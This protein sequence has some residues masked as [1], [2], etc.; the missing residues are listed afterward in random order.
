MRQPQHEARMSIHGKS[1]AQPQSENEL[2][3]SDDVQIS[4]ASQ[5]QYNGYFPVSA[6]PDEKT[7]KYVLPGNPSANSTSGYFGRLWQVGRIVIENNVIELISTIHPTG[8]GP[9]SGILFLAGPL[10][11]QYVFR[12][13]VIRGNIIRHVDNASD[14][15]QFP[16]GISPDNC[17][18]AIVENNDINLDTSIPIRQYNSATL[19]YFNNQTPAGKLIQ[20]N[21]GDNLQNVNELTTDVD[22]AS[23]LS[24]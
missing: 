15:S 16:V 8:W 18:N 10:G 24:S 1:R 17:E 11:T 21:L 23:L 4:K 12:Q 20:G 2:A 19:K 6:D 22:L 13:V 14:P 5:P 7:F 3:V 9:P